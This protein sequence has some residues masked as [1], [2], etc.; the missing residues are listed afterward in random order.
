MT[1]IIKK[2]KSMLP[3]NEDTYN[4]TLIIPHYNIPQL[5]NRLLASVP[6]RK[7]LQV[8]VV[9][10]CSPI[11][12]EELEVIRRNYY[13]VEWYSTNLSGGGGKARNV[14][15]GFALGKHVIFADADDFFETDFN[16]ILDELS[17]KEFD[18]AF[19]KAT[20]VDTDTLQPSYRADHLNRYIDSYLNM[21]D[22]SALFLKYKF[23]EPWCK[24]ISRE[25]IVRNNIHFDETLIHNDTTF[26]Y[27]VGFF[28]RKILV[29]P[30]VLYCVTTR[31]GSVSKLISDERILTRIKVFGKAELFFSQNDIPINID[32][33]YLQLIQL[34]YKLRLS[35]LIKGYNLLRNQGLNSGKI[36]KGIISTSWKVVALRLRKK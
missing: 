22:P 27:L 18:I 1:C 25:L 31:K 4:Y 36:L 21:S 11:G 23:G 6:R 17:S 7:D 5:L 8:I 34:I 26:S 24:I 35:L 14:G 16:H 10:D 32:N 30:E 3:S 19:F 2:A 9:D 28:A 13:W 12:K 20:S 33:H 29:S 15:L